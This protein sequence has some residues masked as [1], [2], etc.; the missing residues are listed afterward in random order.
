MT[1]PNRWPLYS[2]AAA[3]SRVLPSSVDPVNTFGEVELARRLRRETTMTLQWIAENLHV[4]A[5]TNVSNRLRPAPP[6]GIGVKDKD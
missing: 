5:W 4:G 6:K 1:A 2:P 3:S